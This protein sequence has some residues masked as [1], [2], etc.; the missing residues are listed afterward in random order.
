MKYSSVVFPDSCPYVCGIGAVSSLGIDSATH[1]EKILEGK[2]AF[3][4]LAEL[5]G[6]GHAW[7]RIP[8]AWLEDRELF[9]GRRQ[10]PASILAL[11]LARQAVKDAGWGARELESAALIVGSSRGNAMGWLDS[12]S[13]RRKIKLLS[14]P[15]SLH[16]ELASSV[17]IEFGIHGPYHVLASGCA[18]GLD[19]VGLAAMLV[20]S[21]VVE[22]AL[23]IG[24]DL[25]LSPSVLDTYWSSGMLAQVGV[26]NPYGEDADGMVIAEGGGAVALSIHPEEGVPY[27]R[28]LDYRSNSDASS[29]LGMPADG[30]QLGRLIKTSLEKT[31]AVCEALTICPHAS[32]T[33]NNGIAEK[34]ALKYAF[35]GEKGTALCFPDVRL[36]KPWCGHAIGGSGILELC[37]MLA[38]AKRG[39]LPPN[40][41]GM[42]SP[43]EG[44]ILSETCDLLDDR[45]LLKTA[46]SMGGH[47]AVLALSVNPNAPIL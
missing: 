26:N 2:C 16:S 6:E 45:I 15:Q 25:P 11:L 47:N 24:L 8:A 34:A 18:A 5:W 20:E 3:R 9:M 37:M 32:G 14:V 21:G 29:P 39:L 12:I 17:T 43:W 33:R 10:G 30:L 23:A 1:V 13:G 36:M 28:V 35:S 41:P 38:F 19:A 40:L 7:D 44:C 4:P 27:G 22:R 46:S 42:A 31:G